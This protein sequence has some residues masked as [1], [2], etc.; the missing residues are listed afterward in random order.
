MGPIGPELV[1]GWG[2]AARAAGLPD[3]ARAEEAAYGSLG[4]EPITHRRGDVADRWRQRMAEIGQ[5]LDL[6][7]RAG[8]STAFGAGTV[9]SPGGRLTAT[10]PDPGDRMLAALPDLLVGLEWGDAVA[11]V[12]SL[13]LETRNPTPS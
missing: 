12:A 5:S 6:A 2:P 4:F 3:D 8:E 7:D 11:V 9:E 13:D 1:E 10:G